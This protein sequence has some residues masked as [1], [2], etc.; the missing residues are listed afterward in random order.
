MHI[1]S[2]INKI[3]NNFYLSGVSLFS[4]MILARLLGDLTTSIGFILLI[5]YM[6]KGSM[7]V[8]Q[9]LAITWF[10][11]LSNPELFSEFEYL[12]LIRYI[13]IFFAFIISF[14]NINIYN[15]NNFNYLR[16]SKITI[17]ISIFFII[18]G[19]L[20]SNIPEISILKGFL[21]GIVVI[22]IINA[23]SSLT[24]NQVDQ[25]IKWFFGF[26]SLFIMLS[27][28][29]FFF[30]LIGYN[31]NGT[32]FQGILNQ[33]Q[34]FGLTML[35]I[36]YFYL[37]CFN[38]NKIN[39]VR[40]S[41]F[42]IAIV[43]L[44]ESK[45]RTA[46]ALSLFAV[47]AFLLSTA[48]NDMKAYKFQLIKFPVRILIPIF[49]I[50]LVGI[51]IYNSQIYYQL[52]EKGSGVN[53][54]LIDLY[55]NSRS[56]VIEPMLQNIENKFLTGIGFGIASNSDSSIII[57]SSFFDVPI[58]AP[59]EKSLTPLAILEEIGIVGFFLY[60]IFLFVVLRCSISLGLMS[61]LFVGIFILVNFTEAILF[62]IGGMGMIFWVMLG[63]A[64]TRNKEK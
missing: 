12:Y 53:T 30:P 23:W 7:Q 20:I 54:G 60:L 43:L 14:I 52:I 51:F 28:L 47:M 29:M 1:S 4:M 45:S 2:P 13:V 55:I 35:I 49:C 5:I 64:T 21:W 36:I 17:I 25:Q 11:S 24:P 48:F 46:I 38:K 8:I 31:N 3:E 18:H 10:F 39:L 6:K 56:M 9:A 57:R 41:F 22:T 15:T 42:L 34:A 63:W 58:G 40:I 37:L 44:I 59:I 16:L 62:S 32:G 27:A 61:F 19:I 33:P 26:F 50:S